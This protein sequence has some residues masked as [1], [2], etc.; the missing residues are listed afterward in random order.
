ML[1]VV[2]LVT[3]GYLI[4][5]AVIFSI[6]KQHVP[7]PYMDEIFHIPQTRKYCGG[8]FTEVSREVGRRGDTRVTV[9]IIN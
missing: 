4:T 3:G 7:S 9:V 2:S 1:K 8:N 5:L 6:I